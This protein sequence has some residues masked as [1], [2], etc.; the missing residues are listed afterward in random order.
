MGPDLKSGDAVRIAD[1]GARLDRWFARHF[2]Q[3]GRNR[4]FRLLRTGQIR[5]DGKR[6]RVD[7]RL[8]AGQMLRI[9]PQV[10]SSVP[11]SGP[12][13]PSQQE[14]EALRARVLFLD[15]DIIAI[16]KPAGLAAQGGAGQRRHVDGL[17]AALQFDADAPP[18]LV[19][20][21]DKE[22]S[23]VLVLA[24][25]A[26]AAR[27]LAGLFRTGKVEKCYWAVVAGAPRPPQGRI[28][29]PLH[30]RAATTRYRTLDHAGGKAAWLELTP[31][32]GRTHQLRIHC[33]GLG[34]PILGDTKYGRHAAGETPLRSKNLHLHARILRIPG[35]PVIEAPLPAHF[36]DTF[37]G[38]GFTVG[39]GRT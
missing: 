37:S 18:R 23:G 2:P 34:A 4:L 32:T 20:R 30:Q 24:R 26:T 27:W 12:R 6:A 7:T 28:D 31:L 16:D 1:H 38:L 3:V 15:D 13:P 36:R 9:P 21:L 39:Q 11:P 10:R 17:A 29:T 19:H 14:A 33:A 8:E 22:T 35:R 25:H 5:V